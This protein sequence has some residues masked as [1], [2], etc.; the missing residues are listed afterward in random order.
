[1]PAPRRSAF[2]LGALLGGFVLSLYL[3]TGSSDLKHNGDTDL[4]YQT[5]QAIVEYHRLW[6]AHPMWT[7]NRVALGVGRHLYAFYGPGQTILM[8]PLYIV[9]KVIAHHLSLPYDTTTLYAAR[10]LNLF[11]GALVTVMVYVFA[12][13]L[14][15]SLRVSVLIALLFAVGTPAWPD[16]QSA[17]EQTPVDLFLLF[18]TWATWL[19][20]RRG[21]VDRRPLRLVGCGLGLAIWTRYDAAVYVALVATFLASLRYYRGES[22]SIVKDSGILAASLAPWLTMVGVWNYARFGSPFV[23]GLSTP[24]FGTGFWAGFTGL[25]VSPGKGLIWYAPVVLLLPLVGA[26]FYRRNRVMALLFAALI[27]LPILFYS[28]VLYWHGDPAWGPRYLYPALPYLV[29]PLGELFA[30]WKLRRLSLRTTAAV[31]TVVSVGL[32]SAAISVTQ[33]RFWYELEAQRQTTSDASRWSGQ[34]FHWG[35]NRYHYYWDAANSPIVWQLKNVYQ[36]TRLTLG[37]EGY[38]RTLR[39]DPYASNPAD[40][41]PLN[42][43]AFWWT[44]VRQPLLGNRLRMALASFL[45]LTGAIS[46]VWIFLA[47][48]APPEDIRQRVLLP[49]PSP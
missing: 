36:V 29:L 38:R 34:P 47:A 21:L 40:N 14:G 31:L 17:L 28:N 22:R 37:D 19:F 11:L 44:D 23:T 7:D 24:T 26:R 27:L 3:L 15:Y 39:P 46:L 6:I 18:A 25:L 12:L 35:A 45:A 1:M 16:A 2:L 5:T 13:S 32:Q 49:L 9:G 33:W 30:T 8:V 4:R 20:I 43:F 48:R 42:T 41:Y 10:S